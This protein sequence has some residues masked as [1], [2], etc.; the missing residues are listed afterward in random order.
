ME[1]PD[2]PEHGGRSGDRDPSRQAR[3]VRPVTQRLSARFGLDTLAGGTLSVCTD[4]RIRMWNWIEKNN[5]NLI[6]MYPL[7]YHIKF[8]Y[9]HEYPY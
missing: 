3:A 8:K 6:R 9:V 2:L 7:Y 1:A 4:S 5:K